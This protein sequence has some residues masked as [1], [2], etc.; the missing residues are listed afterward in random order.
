MRFKFL[1]GLD[2]DMREQAM[3]DFWHD[4]KKFII[5]GFALLFLSY[6]AGQGYRAYQTHTQEAN[7]LGYYQAS[8]LDTP[9]AYNEFA[10][11]TNDGFQGLALFKAAQKLV[12]EEN[13]DK[14]ERFFAQI[15][16]N[17]SLPTSWQDLAAIRQAELL[18]TLNPEKAQ[19]ILENVVTS[20]SRS[21]DSPYKRTAYELSA[22]EAQN[23]GAYEEAA[24]YYERL[25]QMPD[26]LG[27]MRE[28]IQ[29]RL[30][31]LKGKGYITT[32]GQTSEGTN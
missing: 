7:A 11:Q 13:F 19:T 28:N 2:D 8:Q 17:N 24:G 26:L 4:N 10:E 16:N 23:R 20:D 3:K 27:G 6:G 32:T 22:I 21:G 14:A 31:Y 18:L 1:H 29:Q 12:Q 15:R 5:G 9:Q 25:L 30:S